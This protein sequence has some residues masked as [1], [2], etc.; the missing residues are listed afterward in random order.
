MFVGTAIFALILWAVV[1]SRRSQN[2]NLDSPIEPSSQIDASE[3]ARMLTEAFRQGRQPKPLPFVASSSMGK[4]YLLKAGPFYKI[5]KAKDFDKRLRQIRLQLPYPVEVVHVIST[6]E[7][8]QLETYWHRKFK[9]KRTNG[10]W[11]VLTDQ[12]VKEFVKYSKLNT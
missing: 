6:S 4:V 12:D 2:K 5:G 7:F 1:A 8:S 10:E 9:T 3:A 11:F